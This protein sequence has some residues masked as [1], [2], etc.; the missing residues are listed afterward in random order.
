MRTTKAARSRL[1]VRFMG[2]SSTKCEVQ[3]SKSKLRMFAK[4]RAGSLARSFVAQE[5]A[6]AGG[7][8]QVQADLAGG[9]VAIFQVENHLGAGGHGGDQTVEQLALLEVVRRRVVGGQERL[10]PLGFAVFIAGL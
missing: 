8:L 4:L 2:S 10:E 1:K 6:G 7:I 9:L 3:S 5:V